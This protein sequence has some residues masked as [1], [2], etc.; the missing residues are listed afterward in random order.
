M[1][2]ERIRKLRTGQ[3]LSQE[4]LAD[5]VNVSRQ[6]VSKWETGESVPD[7]ER[8]MLLCRVLDVS[9]DYLLF[10]KEQNDVQPT[11]Q[12]EAKPDKN[13]L[14]YRIAGWITTAV[15]GLGLLVMWVLSTMLLSER[16]EEVAVTDAF[17]GNT[18]YSIQHYGVYDF[19]SFIE[20]YRL[21]ALLFICIIL[22]AAG[23]SVLLW[24]WAKKRWHKKVEE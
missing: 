21:Q 19:V 4:Q 14:G 17:T 12:I 24:Q 3:R 20:T 9:A 16:R 10:G 6:A 13:S 8:L 1:I 7:T 2:G 18:Y 22:L 11:V 15:G 23:I 5:A